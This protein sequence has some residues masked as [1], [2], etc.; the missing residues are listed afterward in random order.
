MKRILLGL[1]LCC[2][3]STLAVAADAPATKS[4]AKP[5]TS[6]VDPALEAAHTKEDVRRHRIMAAAHEA[7]AKCQ[8]SGKDE[9]YCNAEL[10]KACQGI[11]YGKHCGMKHPD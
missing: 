8:E 4:P 6:K 2:T 11:A 3:V 9:D 7:A 1:A 5:A 10:A